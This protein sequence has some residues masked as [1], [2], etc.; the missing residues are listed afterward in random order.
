MK[1]KYIHQTRLFTVIFT[2]A[3]KSLAP[4][5]KRISLKDVRRVMPFTT[6]LLRAP[7]RSVTTHDDIKTVIV[8]ICMK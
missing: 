8:K 1:S 3:S 5:Q 4:Q 2:V 7:I 6:G